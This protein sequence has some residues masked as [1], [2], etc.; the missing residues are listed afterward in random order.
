MIY[1]ARDELGSLGRSFNRM[2]H[3]LQ[4][5]RS[6]DMVDANRQSTG[7]AILPKRC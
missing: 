2:T 3:Q 5:Q 6:D 1:D 7:A 4:S